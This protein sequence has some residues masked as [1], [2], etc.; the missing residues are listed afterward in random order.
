MIT[1]LLDQEETCTWNNLFSHKAGC[2]VLPFQ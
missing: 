2:E 1:L